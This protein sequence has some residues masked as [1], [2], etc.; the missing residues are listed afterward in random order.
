MSSGLF[1]FSINK[2]S[3]RVWAQFEKW[4]YDQGRRDSQYLPRRP[5]LCF[6]L[7]D[8]PEAAG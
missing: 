6:C 8:K 4:K 3:R 5:V 2:I 1:D 7:P